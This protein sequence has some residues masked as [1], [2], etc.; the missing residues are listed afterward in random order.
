MSRMAPALLR[1]GTVAKNVYLDYNATTP[2]APEVLDAMSS[3]FTER[4]WNAASSHP[5]GMVANDA[6]EA[7]RRQVAGLIGAHPNGIPFWQA[8][9]RVGGGI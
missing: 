8:P 4:F 1:E 5:M 6:V 3:W 7:A 2:V 9:R